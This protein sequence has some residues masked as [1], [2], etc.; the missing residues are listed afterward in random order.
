MN[1]LHMFCC[2]KT[3]G[4]PINMVGHSWHMFNVWLLM[5]DDG[6]RAYQPF[7]YVLIFARRYG[8]I[9]YVKAILGAG[10]FS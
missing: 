4:K 5:D 1:R 6:C 7:I 9:Y 10:Y 3:Y 8:D 2:V